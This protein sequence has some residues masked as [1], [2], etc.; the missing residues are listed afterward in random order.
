MDQV[1]Q[2]N[3]ANAEESASAAEEMNGQ[4]GQ[5]KGVVQD[6][7]AMVGGS[8]N[9]NG[10]VAFEKDQNIGISNSHST[11]AGPSP[12]NGGRKTVTA[13][14]KRDK[15]AERVALQRNKEVKPEQVI[16]MGEGDFK[17]F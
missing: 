16:P 15:K 1:V 14:G 7:S 3:A 8:R 13:S 6:L 17:E 12:G 2:K 9:G 4:A 10:V 11:S 5:M